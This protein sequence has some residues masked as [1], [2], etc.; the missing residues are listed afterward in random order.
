MPKLFSIKAGL[1]KMDKIILVPK[2]MIVIN[3]GASIFHEIPLTIITPTI[4][5]QITSVVPK[6]FCNKISPIG[7]IEIPAIFISSLKSVSNDLLKVNWLC[8][9]TILAS[10]KI[11]TIFINSEGCTLIGPNLYQLFAPFII[12]VNGVSGIT[13]N[14][15]KVAQRRKYNKYVY[16][17][18]FLGETSI[19]RNAINPPKI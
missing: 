8:F 13:I 6:S 5:A 19:M 18:S 12:G 16:F 17:I 7:I 10:A 9:V 3:N 1:Y 2:I 4:M 14:I 15:N 11:N